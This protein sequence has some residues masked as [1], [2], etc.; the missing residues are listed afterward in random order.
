MSAAAT[1]SKGAGE[2]VPIADRMRYMQGFRLLLAVAV[3]LVAL[4][5]GDRL[6]ATPIALAIGTAAYLGLSGLTHLAWRVS[7][8]VGQG[9][10]GFMLMVDGV[11]LAWTSYATGGAVSPLRFVIALHLVTVALLASYRTGMKLALWH[12][13]LLLVLYYAQE[14][15]LLAPVDERAAIGSPFSLLI[16]YSL[17]FWFVAIATA[18]FSAVNE[19]ELR[20][21]RVDLEALAA[22]ATRLEDVEDSATVADTL[23]EGIVDAFEFERAVLFGAPN[24]TDLVL[25]SQS[26]RVDSGAPPVDLVEASVLATAMRTKERMLLSKLDQGDDPWLAALLP[27]ARQLVVVP[28]WA[29]GHSIGVLVAEHSLRAGS[30]IEHRVVTMVERFCSHGALA[31]RNAWL[32]E[33]VRAMAATDGL[34][35]IANRATFNTTLERELSRAARAQ[36]DASLVLMDIDHFK[37]LN[38][39]YGHQTGDDVLKRVAATL[40]EAARLYDTPARYGGEEFGVIL[41]RTSPAD[42]LMVADRL[43]EAIAASGDD[44]GVTISAG[45]ASF[46]LD[47]TDPDSLVGA[48]DGALYASKHAGRNRVTSVADA[49][50]APT[51]VPDPVSAHAPVPAADPAPLPSPVPAPLPSPVSAPARAPLR[52]TG[53]IRSVKRVIDRFR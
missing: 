21:R 48:A 1:T 40:K 53:Q 47:A 12:S 15:A 4:I 13:L 27:G 33:Q 16:A 17:I 6:E 14:A 30:R 51:L 37:K 5:V 23:L 41:P 39:T 10:F 9:L 11:Y 35:G 7:R 34:T 36:E 32:L 42:A 8:K 26:G 31:L 46:P 28:L 3:G 49:K 52:R 24:E 22:L 50:R 25:L 44:P 45:V 29:E 43:R 19:R 2:L 20:R 38:D 18:S